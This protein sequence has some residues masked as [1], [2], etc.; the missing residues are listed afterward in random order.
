MSDLLPRREFQDITD[1][2]PSPDQ[3]EL[4]H[5]PSKP[6]DTTVI[7]ARRPM[8]KKTLF[9]KD[10]KT[11]HRL[12]PLGLGGSSS[13]TSQGLGLGPASPG[14]DATSPESHELD[15]NSPDGEEVSSQRPMVN[16][17]DDQTSS[18]PHPDQPES[19]R[20]RNMDRDIGNHW[21]EQLQ[22]DAQQ[23][24]ETLDILSAFQQSEEF[25]FLLTFM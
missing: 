25:P 14:L 1:E 5:L 10:W 18:V 8:V 22:V 20:P 9:E 19:K 15:P 6:D 3:L 23:E 11:I 24:A 2:V 7:P 17:Y 21:I 4:P 12:T 16:D 13:S